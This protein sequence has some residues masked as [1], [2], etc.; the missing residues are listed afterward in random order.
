MFSLGSDGLR[1][2][3]RRDGRAE[4]FFDLQ[5]QQA[6]FLVARKSHAD[7]LRA[8]A[9]CVRRRDP[10]HLAGHRVAL[11]II[12]QRKQQVDVVAQPIVAL[13]GHEQAAFA[14]H[15]NEGGVERALLAKNQLNDARPRPAG[16]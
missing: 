8:A 1:G 2:L 6:G 16:Q 13:G 11:R 3:G 10:G 7:A 9:R 12:G 4:D 15:R 5:P 14:E